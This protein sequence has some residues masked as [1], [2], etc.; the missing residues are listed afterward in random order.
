MFNIYYSLFGFIGHVREIMSVY[1]KHSEGAWAGKSTIE[2]NCLLKNYIDEYNAFLDF[3]FDPEFQTVQNKIDQNL[4]YLGIKTQTDITIID[5]IFPHPLSAFRF[6]E[7]LSYLKAFENIEIFCSGISYRVLGND[8][9]DQKI[10]DFKKEYPLYAKKVK[11]YFSNSIINSRLIYTVFLGN[12]FVNI[13]R[14]DELNIPFVF[15]LYPGGMF[16]LNNPQSD[17]FLRRITS[18]PNF[19]KVIV[20]QQIT[21]DYLVDN[22]F[23]KPEQIK[24]IYGVVTPL[25]RFENKYVKKCYF[26]YD[27]HNLDIC[28]VAHKYTK[29][30]VDK[31]FDVFISVAKILAKKYSNIFFHVVGGFNKDDAD[32]TGIEDRIF[33]YGSQSMEWF[34]KF[35]EEK[36][37][38]LSPNIPNKIFTG[39]FDGFP[40]GSCT[41]AGLREVSMFCTDE[42]HLNSRFENGKDIVIVPHDASQIAAII[43][44]YYKSPEELRAIAINGAEKIKEI[45]GYSQQILPRIELLKQEIESVNRVMVPENISI[46]STEQELVKLTRNGLFSK[47]L[48]FIKKITPKFIKNKIRSIYLYLKSRPLIKKILIRI[49][50][51]KIREYLKSF[52]G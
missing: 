14:I 19:R 30:G 13:D 29:Y 9:L 42:M 4:K 1:R 46:S 26:G 47:M 39:S 20:T 49:I 23:C 34:D 52:I 51:N 24:F 3:E 41:D 8:S 31:G 35:Y 18:S 21:Y 43:Q 17:N 33:F 2:Q 22:N 6:Q 45:Y 38:I 37:I 10:I 11:K 28:F 44:R 25:N 7:F 48:L 40:T 36:D 15:T 32:I 5:D 16:G 50:P 12:T 27:K